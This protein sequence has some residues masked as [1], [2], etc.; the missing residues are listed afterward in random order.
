[1]SRTT[2][3][4]TYEYMAP[5]MALEKSYDYRID[6]W[7]LGVLLYE[8]VHGKAPFPAE[9]LKVMKEKINKGSYEI[10]NKCSSALKDLIVDLLQFVPEKRLSIQS[11]QNHPWVKQCQNL[12]HNSNGLI[13]EIIQA[14][15]G[16]KDK[17]L[18]P[19]KHGYQRSMGNMNNYS[20]VPKNK[21]NFMETDTYFKMKQNFL[22]NGGESE[23]EHPKT[24]EVKKHKRNVTQPYHKLTQGC[25]DD[26]DKFNLKKAQMLIG[27][28]KTEADTPQ[29]AHHEQKQ[30]SIVPKFKKKCKTQGEED[31]SRFEAQYS[32]KKPYDYESPESRKKRAMQTETGPLISGYTSHLRNYSSGQLKENDPAN[33][34]SLNREKVK[35]R[36]KA[37]E[38]G[39]S[40]MKRIEEK[41]LEIS[42]KLM[43][44]ERG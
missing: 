14:S 13:E 34:F 25:E 7:A 24:V 16:V 42:A 41:F 12:T 9:S 2:F 38:K 40:K 29:A 39:S 20:E 31:F 4:G 21:S 43:N 32:M 18:E 23:L 44:K 15:Q 1:M 8:L 22:G 36:P 10:N 27:S 30:P 11:I 3:C 35:K 6:I 26:Y 5:E 19:K 28:M 37:Q 33:L 17:K